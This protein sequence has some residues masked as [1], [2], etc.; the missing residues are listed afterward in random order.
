MN[1]W[2]GFAITFFTSLLTA[3][4]T[5]VVV[6]RLGVFE[7]AGPEQVQLPNLVGMDQ[8]EA[9]NHLAVLGLLALPE[10]EA[11]SEVEADKVIR[12][13]IAPGQRVDKGQSIVLTVAEALP[14]VPRLLG[15]TPDEARLLVDKSGLKL[16]VGEPIPSDSVEAGK[17]ADQAPTAGAN[18]EKGETVLI[19]VSSG[20]SAVEMPN[21]SGTN[22]Q[23]AKQQ[24]EALKLE[25]NVR[26]VSLPET[27]EYQVLS[28]NPAPGAKL[29]VGAKVELVVNR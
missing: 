18:I 12:Q 11:S 28:Q 27:F 14:E 4:G 26:W 10:R 21:V 15:K 13:S 7:H 22:Y 2:T 23:N 17:I 8:A 24:L 3:S 25:V 20:P 9:S 1:A 5:A 29:D 16:H 6:D 19:Q